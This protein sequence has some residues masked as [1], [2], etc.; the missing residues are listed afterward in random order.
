MIING[1]RAESR[2]A[3]AAFLAFVPVKLNN[4]FYPL[5]LDL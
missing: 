1:V 4:D 5:G 3:S 2:A